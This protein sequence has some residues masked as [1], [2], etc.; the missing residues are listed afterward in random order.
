MNRARWSLLA[1]IVV[2]AVV[3][4]Y[5]AWDQILRG[6]NVAALA[7]SSAGP[8]SGAPAS[9]ATLSSPAQA[10]GTWNV[11][12]TSV[13]GYRVLEK[14]AVLPAQSDAVGRTSS[15][16]G[17][18]TLAADG[19][20]LQVAAA[21]F[22]ADLTTLTSDKNMRDQRLHAI[23]L[24]SDRYPTSTFKLTS[25]VAVP[26]SALS[27]QTQSVTLTG[28]FTLHGVT[29]SVSIPVQ[30]RMAGGQIEIAGSLTFP[31]ADYSIDPP[32]VAG[33]VSVTDQATLEFDVLLDHA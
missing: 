10:A 29:R 22:Q 17:S 7:L 5:V 30:A 33:L 13:V 27:G 3:G 31:M 21:Q 28:D 8:S 15:V 18:A 9:S 23:G 24:E 25:A 20:G 11:A 16:T 26:V 19:S 6:D 32:N 1:A 2:V 14:L 4:G 12:G